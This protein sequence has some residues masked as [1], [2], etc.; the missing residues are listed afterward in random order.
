VLL[1]FWAVAVGEEEGGE[2]GEEDQQCWGPV[3]AGAEAV[4]AAVAAVAVGERLYLKG[5]VEV[6]LPTEAPGV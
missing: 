4:V 2:E 6:H 3:E 1:H 5:V